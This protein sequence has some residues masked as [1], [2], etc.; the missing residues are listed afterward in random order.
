MPIPKIVARLNRVVTNRVTVL[1]AGWMPGFGVVLHQGRRSGRP[2]RT[3]V[4]AFRLPDG[5]VIALTYGADAD[6]VKNVQAANGC[7]LEVRRRPA[8][9]VDPRIVH[10]KTRHDMPPVVR[11]ILGL[12][13]VTDF[14]YLASESEEPAQR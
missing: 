12:L 3:P 6:W 2:Y 10:D 7:V 8:R 1:F 5:Y 9:L 11:Q 13:S 4:N 14:L